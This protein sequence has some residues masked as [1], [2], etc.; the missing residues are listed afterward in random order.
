MVSAAPTG[1]SLAVSSRLLR[2]RRSMREL[3][4]GVSVNETSIETI[5][6]NAIVQP[7]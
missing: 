6:E 5:I 4:I 1:A 7:N 3:S 2:R